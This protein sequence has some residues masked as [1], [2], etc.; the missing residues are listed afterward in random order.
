MLPELVIK[1]LRCSDFQRLD[2]GLAAVLDFV[3][4]LLLWLDFGDFIEKLIAIV[5]LEETTRLYDLV[6]HDRFGFVLFL[7]LVPVHADRRAKFAFF[8]SENSHRTLL[9]AISSDQIF[10][11]DCHSIC[12]FLDFP[13]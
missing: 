11:Y 2:C 8:G 12:I 7:N 9:V 4:R 3:A 10:I 13:L 6:V 1:C 5:L